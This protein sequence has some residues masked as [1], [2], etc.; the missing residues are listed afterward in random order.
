[1]G[2]TTELILKLVS[3][4]LV[5]CVA[6]QAWAFSQRESGMEMS[7]MALAVDAETSPVGSAEA[8]NDSAQATA[9]G[10]GA[11]KPEE[12]AKVAAKEGA[13]DPVE[14]KPSDD[15]KKKDGEG[16]KKDDKKR[17]GPPFPEEFKGIAESGVFG[18]PPVKKKPPP[19][20]V[21]FV[22]KYA[23]IRGPSGK[24]DLVAEGK[25]FDGVKVL[26]IDTNRVLVE[27][28]GKQ[29]ELTV[30]SGLGSSTLMQKDPKKSDS[31][32][33][34]AAKDQDAAN[35]GSDGKKSNNA[36]E[37]TKNKAPQKETKS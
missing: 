29:L 10:S 17:P 8:T 35:K 21:G 3:L 31:E 1:M 16:D 20:L 5:V 22:G 11:S 25:E 30:F 7:S 9:D 15:A 34:P 32:K 14:S 24:E 13:Q 36:A 27:N 19:S 23:I 12:G 6:Y 26:K 4:V 37:E 33:R 2:K 18:K 28:D